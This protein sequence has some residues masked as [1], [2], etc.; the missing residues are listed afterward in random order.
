MRLVVLAVLAASAWISAASSQ[1]VHDVTAP[2]PYV[3]WYAPAQ[4]SGTILD[5]TGETFYLGYSANPDPAGAC[6]YT[7]PDALVTQR[8]PVRNGGAPAATWRRGRVIG[9]TSLTTPTSILAS[10]GGYCNSAA[11]L[12]DNGASTFFR[13][14]SPRIDRVW[15]GIRFGASLCM[16]SVCRFEIE[17]AWISNVRDDALEV[18]MLWGGSLTDS[19]I[20]GV[21]SG[22]SSNPGCSPASTNPACVSH[23]ADTLLVDRTL[24]RLRG[25][26]HADGG[27]YH[28]AFLKLNPGYSPPVDVFGTVVAAESYRPT[29]TEANVVAWDRTW[30]GIRNCGNNVLLWLPDTPIPD[31]M[32]LHMPTCFRII[33]GAEARGYW[34]GARDQWAMRHP[35]VDRMP[36]E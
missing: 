3:Q 19:L 33:Q 23:A 27:I 8:Y 30:Q 24:I 18:D 35:D 20:D 31:R 28:T 7:L 16:P 12:M 36:G 21:F 29:G 13:V 9:N 34:N 10:N 1:A 17:G 15:D 5:A 11:I 32:I 22:V 6:R 25:F 2:A 4:P 26:P 14:E